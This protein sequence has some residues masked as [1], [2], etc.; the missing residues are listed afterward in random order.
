MSKLQEFQVSKTGNAQEGG[1]ETE[2]GVGIEDGGPWVDAWM[3]RGLANRLLKLFLRVWRS[4]RT[5]EV[6]RE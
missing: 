6:E 5:F 2:L 3:N 4:D 1:I